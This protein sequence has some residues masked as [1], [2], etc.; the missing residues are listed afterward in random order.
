MNFK[1]IVKKVNLHVGSQGTIVS[2]EA[3]DYQEYLA[4]AVRSAWSNLQN[5]RQDWKFMWQTATFNTALNQTLYPDTDIMT[6][7]GSDHGVAKWKTDSIFKDGEKQIEMDF[8]EYWD[9]SDD[10][11]ASLNN[12]KFAVQDYRPSGLIIPS[13]DG[14]SV[15]RAD[16][17]RTAQLM[18]T[19]LDVPLLPEEFHYIIVWQALEDVASY[20]GNQAIYERHSWKYD[21]LLPKLMRSQVPAKRAKKRPL[22]RSR[23]NQYT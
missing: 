13:A 11:D 22:Y 6:A 15:I 4:E 1:T 19:N 23:I 3:T 12:N 5:E 16:Y 17:Y 18:T 9:N 21:V 7:I 2:V 10:Y 14:P 8:Q 20:L